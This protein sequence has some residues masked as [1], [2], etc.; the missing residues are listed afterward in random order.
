[1]KTHRSPS[2]FTAFL[3]LLLG[4][5]LALQV[6]A[7]A[8]RLELRPNLQPLPAWNISLMGGLLF[9]NTTSWNSGNGPLELIAGQ[10]DSRAKKQKVYQ[11]VY[12]NDGT[13]YDHLAGD[14]V[15]HKLHNHFHFE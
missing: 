5:L 6:T 4:A 11:R 7:F 13:F 14:F 1:M 2:H 8:Q 15:W 12:Y 9:F 3:G 10:V